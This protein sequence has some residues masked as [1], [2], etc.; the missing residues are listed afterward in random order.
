MAFRRTRPAGGEESDMTAEAPRGVAVV[1]GGSAGLGRAIV[2]ELAAR[3][4][5]QVPKDAVFYRGAGCEECRSFGYRG[6]TALFELMDFTPAVRGAFLR[7]ASEDELTR[8]VVQDG[9]RTI[10]ADGIR[11]AVEGVTTVDE[12]LRVAMNR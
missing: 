6:R 9:M 10:V 4:G 8:F 3:G 11:K 12:V 1:T 5:Y 7:G 2:R